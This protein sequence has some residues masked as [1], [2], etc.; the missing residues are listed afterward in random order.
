MNRRD[1]LKYTTTI[2]GYTIAGS[3]LVSMVQSC[4]SP[5]EAA[6]AYFTSGEFDLLH[7]I[8][9]SILP[10]SDTPGALS[11]QV[12][13]FIELLCSEVF[14]EEDGRAVKKGLIDFELECKKKYNRAFSDLNK[15]EKEAHLVELDKESAHFPITMWG[16]NLDPNPKPISFYRKLKS[17][18]LQGYFTSEKIGKEILV[19]KPVPGQFIG[20]VEYKG[21]RL[22]G[23]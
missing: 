20:C 13:Q 7:E 1:Y 10:E 15:S 18:V 8:A 19:Y 12:P 14:S 17:M 5:A 3:S 16:I 9:G 6:S 22:Y 21:E 11:M 23:D 2:L 4:K